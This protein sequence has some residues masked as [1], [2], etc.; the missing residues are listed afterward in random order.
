VLDAF[1][2][3][4]GNPLYL[5]LGFEEARRWRSGQEPQR[6]ARGE[7]VDGRRINPVEAIIEQN[8]FARLASDDN[9]GPVLVAHALG[10]IAASRHGLAEDELLELLSRD[11]DVYTSFLLGSYH[12]PPDLRTYLDDHLSSDT[13][14]SATGDLDA[15]SEWVRE[16]RNGERSTTELTDLLDVIHAWPTEPPDS[17][18]VERQDALRLPVVLWSRLYADLQPYLTETANE[19][20]VTIDFYHREL[21]AVARTR[22]LAGEMANILHS[23]LADYFRAKANPRDDHTWTTDGET[24]NRRG[25]SELPHHLVHAK[26]WDDIYETLTDFMF[27][28]QK[29]EK[30]AVTPGA[31]EHEPVYRGVF[32]LQDDF[33]AALSGTRREGDDNRRRIIVTAADLGNGLEIRCPHCSRMIPWDDDYRDTLMTCPLEEPGCGGPLKVN[34]FVVGRQV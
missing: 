20:A 34:T 21:D 19:D 12:V 24:V 16:V 11:P 9:H 27:L 14:S 31:N 29:V 1:E 22:F 23:R 32:A 13:L 28:E 15:A 4:E 10:Y 17:G 7:V 5:R 33:D 8:T 18:P 6:L 2:D 3:A 26:R 25:L 30:V